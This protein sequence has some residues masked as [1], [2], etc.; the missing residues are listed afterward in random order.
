MLW[1]TYFR[2]YPPFGTGAAFRWPGKRGW[3]WRTAELA[4]DESGCAT[5]DVRGMVA[6]GQAVPWGWEPPLDGHPFG[7]VAAFFRGERFGTTGFVYAYVAV[8]QHNAPRIRSDEF[9]HSVTSMIEV[10]V[11][12][13]QW[14]V[15]FRLYGR[16]AG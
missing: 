15:K 12:C 4:C 3:C 1:G 8:R 14:P 13:F 11:R 6:Q 9:V 10:V 16:S 5:V 2:G 7:R